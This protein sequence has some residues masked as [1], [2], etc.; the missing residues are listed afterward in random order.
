M[1]RLE[2]LPERLPALAAVL[3]RQRRANALRLGGIIHERAVRRRWPRDLAERY[4]GELI[5][6]DFTPQRLRGLE[7]FFEKA[8]EHGLIERCRAIVFAPG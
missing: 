3:D 8:R 4:L 5:A 6:T 2:A 7:L 1:A